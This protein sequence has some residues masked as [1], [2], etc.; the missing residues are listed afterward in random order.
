VLSQ[1]I[2][3][4]DRTRT[5]AFPRG[6]FALHAMPASAGIETV[7]AASYSWDGLRRG[8]TPFVV[9]Q[10]T[11][12]GQGMLIHEDRLF[13]LLPGETMLV[14]IP[15]A[16][17]YFLPP[18]GRW[19]FF[20]LVLQGQEVLRL[21][22]EAIGTGG[23]VHRPSPQALDRVASV[24]A[25]LLAGD[26]ATPGRASSLAYDAAMALIDDLSGAGAPDGDADRPAWLARVL[27][28]IDA[29]PEQNLA[30]E[31]LAALAG[32]SRAHFVRQFTRRLAASP[33]D[34]VFRARM[35]RAAR[36]LQASSLTIGEIGRSLGFADANYFAKAFRRAFA[37]SPT[38]FRRSGLFTPV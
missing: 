6:R 24:V 20:F 18:G 9:I 28:Q 26:A 1:L 36:L 30:V 16:H 22:G 27:A 7:A 25:A 34:Y 11:L 23:P 8:L 19:R 5:I 15:H 31:R 10:H 14:T 35:A 37:V 29:H 21:V 2:D 12:E 33:A 3:L 13:P 38:E 4:P 17:R 32:L